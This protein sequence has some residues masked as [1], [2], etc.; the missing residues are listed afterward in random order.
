MWFT[1]DAAN[2]IGRIT[3]A[4][5]I[6]EY[7]VPTANSYPELIM[8]RPDGALWFTEYSR[9]KI[10]RITTAGIVTEYAA[11]TGPSGFGTGL[12]AITTGQDGNLWFTQ[13][14]N[15]I[16]EAVFVTATLNVSPPSNFCGTNLTFTGSGFAPG[17]SVRI[18]QS[19]VGSAVLASPSADSSGSFTAT[20]RVPQSP[21][22]PRIF[23]GKGQ[24]SNKLGAASFSVTPLLTLNPGTG[25]VGSTVTAEGY[26]FGSLEKVNV[27]WNDLRTLLGTVT[28]DVHEAFHG[29]AALSFEVPAGAPSGA[30]TVSGAGQTTA[31]HVGRYFTVQ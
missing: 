1:E 6:T 23:L 13:L 4:G 21:Y 26:G 17:E 7:L 29:S 8:A 15:E 12:G 28:T 30:D 2:Q 25:A 31:A 18:Y 9:N 24:T 5:V 10:G 16:G 19:G 22:G 27:Y 20:A 11:P 14:A 3:T